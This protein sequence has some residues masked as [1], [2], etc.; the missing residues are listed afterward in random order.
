MTSFGFAVIVGSEGATVSTGFTV[1]SSLRR[2]WVSGIGGRRAR[3]LAVT[4][5]V[6]TI[7]SDSPPTLSFAF[8]FSRSSEGGV[9][10]VAQRL[11]RL[12]QSRP[13]RPAGN[14]GTVEN[15]GEYIV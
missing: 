6:G 13:D 15:N 7:F 11:G 12:I 8:S 1:S 9:G 4:R 3:P 14:E 10:V 2:G 5:V